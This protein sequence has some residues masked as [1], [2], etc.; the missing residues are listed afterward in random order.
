M[1]FVQGRVGAVPPDI[2]I[3]RLRYILGNKIDLHTSLPLGFGCNISVVSC[4][5]N[6]GVPGCTI[7]KILDFQRPLL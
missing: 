7:C 5:P 3:I 2:S 6:T 4:A 1:N